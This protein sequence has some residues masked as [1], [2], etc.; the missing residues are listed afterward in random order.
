[1]FHLFGAQKCGRN[2]EVVITRGSTV[3]ETEK[4]GEHA[5]HVATICIFK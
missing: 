5:Y 2:D 1:M 4:F 3:A